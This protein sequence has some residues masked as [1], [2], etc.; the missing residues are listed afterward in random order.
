MRTGLFSLLLILTLPAKLVSADPLHMFDFHDTHDDTSYF[1]D[2]HNDYDEHDY[3]SL[4]YNDHGHAYLGREILPLPDS[5][6]WRD[7]TPETINPDALINPEILDDFRRHRAPGR[8]RQPTANTTPLPHRHQAPHRKPGTPHRH[9]S[10][11]KRIHQPPV[12]S[13]ATA[14]Q[15]LYLSGRQCR[16]ILRKNGVRFKT[17]KAR[18]GVKYPLWIQSK[19]GGVRYRQSHRH[20]RL[21]VM[22]CRLAVALLSWSRILRRQGIYE[23]V[24][25]RTWS[26]GATVRRTGRPSGHRWALAIDVTRFKSRR[27]GTIHVKYDWLD[28]R[29]GISPCRHARRREATNQK[30]L[31]TVVCQSANRRLFAVILT[32]HYNRAHH[33]HLHIE[34][35]P[36]TYRMV[37][38]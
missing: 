6:R 33:N 35:R 27:Y 17:L 11:P 5:P 24:Y 22:D 12:A 29:K 1:Y 37:L 32:P 3:A 36:N 9:T 8:K 13:P 28:R 34:L 19:L 23:V 20:R 26:P 10:R 21:P 2:E 14:Y 38:R 16:A 4:D 15:V 31:R 30:I 25:S 18:R 7:E